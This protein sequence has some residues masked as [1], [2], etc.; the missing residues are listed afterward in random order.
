MVTIKSSTFLCPCFYRIAF[1][2][3][4]FFS[5][6]RKTRTFFLC[7]HTRIPYILIRKNLR[8]T[9]DIGKVTSNLTELTKSIEDD[10]D[11]LVVIVTGYTEPMNKFFDSNPGLAA[12]SLSAARNCC[13][14]TGF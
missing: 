8:F 12:V 7:S 3:K 9:Y 11:D 13:N 6:V 14:H 2:N 10:R 5:I 4:T 1:L